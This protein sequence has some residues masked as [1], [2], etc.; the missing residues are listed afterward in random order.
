MSPE[1]SKSIGKLAV[2]ANN[3]A[4]PLI[5]RPHFSS[6]H[7]YTTIIASIEIKCRVFLRGDDS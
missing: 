4:T 1:N 6:D 7:D 2:M 3:V 5:L